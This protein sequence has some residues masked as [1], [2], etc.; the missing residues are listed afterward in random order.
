MSGYLS[1]V[2]QPQP[3]AS[4]WF[5]EYV[6]NGYMPEGRM[7]C[8][9]SLSRGYSVSGISISSQIVLTSTTCVYIRQSAENITDRQVYFGTKKI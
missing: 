2:D 5:T 4:R 8:G 1:E 7:T 6:M 3:R 9:P